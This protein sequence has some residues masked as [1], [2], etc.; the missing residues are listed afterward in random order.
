MKQYETFGLEFK[1]E[2]PAGS[3]VQIDLTAEF[4][5]NGDSKKVKGFYAGNG[6]YK[7]RFLP[8]KTGIYTW[9]VSGIISESG[10]EICKKSEKSHGLL[11]AVDTHFE[12]E[13]GTRFIPFGTTIYALANQTEQLIAETMESLKNSPFNK[14][15]H[16]VF[17]KDYEFNHNEPDFYPFEKDENGKWD[18]HRPCFAFWDHFDTVLKKLA[19]LGIQSDLILFHPYDRWGFAELSLEDNK[20][21]L[22]YL[23]RRLSANP[24][25]WWSM[26]NE[27]DL[28]YFKTMEDW[29]A[30]EETVVKN[31]NY[32]H[33]LSNHNCFLF[34]DFHRKNVTHCSCQTVQIFKAAKFMKEYRKPVC[35][36]ECCYEGDIEPEWG[37][38]SAKEMVAR[39]WRAYSV[40]AFATHGETFR[41]DDE[42]LW[43][44][45][46]GRLKGQSPER[47]AFL[48]SIVEEL[49]GV[50]EP[51]TPDMGFADAG[52]NMA[53]SPIFK[54]VKKWFTTL[55]E[56]QLAFGEEKA[57][58]YT[59]KTEH[60]FIRYFNIECISQAHMNLPEDKDYRIEVI[61]TWNMTRT[62]YAEHA[63]GSVI[64][65]L[66]GKEGM[67]VLATENR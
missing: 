4:I 58:K 20:V 5:C 57:T 8:Q 23:L 51:W 27:Y 1:A 45:K 14:L 37:N 64:V 44:S 46:G 52:G 62:V 65:E 47:I 53:D 29:Y 54:Q 12:F 25:I 30:L 39:F 32:G 16:C 59:G 11:K 34:Y 36:D 43:W 63:S 41:S 19:D 24:S 31:D 35:F 26:A 61:D 3:Q 17:P 28:V 66:P 40:G 21:Y 55:S 67:A 49:D 18:V 42:I 48:K 9:K 56:E 22:D 60:A 38:I 10:Q 15:R 13:D 33:L 2:E 50:I 7:V 6:I